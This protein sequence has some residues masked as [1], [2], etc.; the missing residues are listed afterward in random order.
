VATDGTR[1]CE[2]TGKDDTMKK[3]LFNLYIA[4]MELKGFGEYKCWGVVIRDLRFVSNRKER[5]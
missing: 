4:G 2:D 1:I 3:P 5:K